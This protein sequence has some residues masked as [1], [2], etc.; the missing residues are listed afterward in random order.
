MLL[1]GL[2]FADIGSI[3]DALG[4]IGNQLC[5]RDADLLH[6]V[7]VADGHALILLVRIEIIGNAVRRADLILT[8]IALADRAGVV[9]I[10]HEMLGEHLIDLVGLLGKLLGERQHCAL[11]R[12]EH[13]VEVHDGAHIL[14]ALCIGAEHLGVIGFGQDREEQ[15]LHAERRL[16]D[17]RDIA[18]ICL[19]I[20]V[21][22][23]LAGGIAVLREVVVGS[24]G[25][26]PELAPAE[27]EQILKVSRRLGIE[28]KLLCGVVAQAEI[29]LLQ[30]DLQQEVLAVAAPVL[31]PFQIGVGLAEEFQLHLL[32]FA[33]AENEVAGRDLIA[34]GFA[35]LADAER[36]LAARSALDIGKVDE[37]AL[38]R[39]R[40]EIQLGFAVLGN[41]LEGLEHQVEL[42]DIGEIRLAAVRADDALFADVVHHLLIRPARDIRAVEI[43]DEIVC[44]VTRFAL[45]AVHE[46]IGESA[47]V[48]GGDP[49]LRVHEDRAVQTDIVRIGLHEEMPPC[50]F[51]V[52]FELNAERAVVPC[53]CEAA[54]DLGACVHKAAP[55]TESDELIHLLVRIFHAKN[56]LSIIC[57]FIIKQK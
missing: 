11:E 24:V 52:V 29:L 14:L 10:D 55:L 8:A 27:R 13:R 43:L 56:R 47:E 23:R 39:F 17:I 7:A 34:E 36:D 40:T 3:V 1:R 28:A 57:L 20:E 12:R 37:D 49:C 38:C 30:T 25:N 41:A 46:R 26:A 48:T 51:D 21:I 33:D 16:N 42:A 45:A 54:V 6:R 4:E 5:D 9:E 2:C 53:I 32:K 22:K 44:A 50:L 19:R 15:T 31:E 35:D 18:L